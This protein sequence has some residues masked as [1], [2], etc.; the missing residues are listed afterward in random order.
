[1]GVSAGSANVEGCV[2]EGCHW[3]AASACPLMKFL[4]DLTVGAISVECHGLSSAVP[5]SW[6]PAWL[7][8]SNPTNSSNPQSSTMENSCKSFTVYKE[9]HL[10]LFWSTM[11]KTMEWVIKNKNGKMHFNKT[12]TWNI[13]SLF[14]LP[15]FVF[16]CFPASSCLAVKCL[17]KEESELRWGGVSVWWVWTSQVI[18][19]GNEAVAV[20]SSN[21]DFFLH[22]NKLR[23]A[24]SAEF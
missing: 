13:K 20:W 15:W 23:S 3:T 7:G 5:C 8:S 14:Y 11:T 22:Q 17:I 10:A 12:L 6:E 4:T 1:M 2:W 16:T 9:V 18:D 19:S 21:C 24:G